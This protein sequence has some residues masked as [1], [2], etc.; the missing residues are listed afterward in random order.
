[1]N[2]IAVRGSRILRLAKKTPYYYEIKQILCYCDSVIDPCSLFTGYF[3]VDDLLF[4][5]AGKSCYEDL[6]KI[7]SKIGVL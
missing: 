5:A 1:M 6:I 4:I 7:L 2:D 3:V